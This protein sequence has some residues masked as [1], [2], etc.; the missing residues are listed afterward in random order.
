MSGGGD[1]M[2][3]LIKSLLDFAVLIGIYFHLFFKKLKSA[4]KDKLLVNTLMYVYISFVIYFTLMPVLA[5]LPFIFDHPYAPMHLL[6]FDDYLSGR[7]D[8][9]RQI[10]LNVLMMVPFGF[11]LPI[12]RRQTLWSCILWTF[13]FSLGIEL[14]QPLINPIRSSDITDLI[15]NT[16]GGTIGY[17]FYRLFRPLVESGLKSL[18]EKP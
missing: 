13:L 4:G 14:L 18:R 5:S 16:I 3:N 12:L 8:A 17:A 6:P 7:G 11:L 10:L 2:G 15:T 9:E 1:C